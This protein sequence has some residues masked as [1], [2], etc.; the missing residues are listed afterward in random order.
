MPLW[1]MCMMQSQPGLQPI[2]GRLVDSLIAGLSA[3]L[4]SLSSL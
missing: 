1:G 3:N 2:V 4:A